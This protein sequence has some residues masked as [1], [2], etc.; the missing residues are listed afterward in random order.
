MPVV[1]YEAAAVI[2]VLIL[3]GKYLETRATG[4]TGAAIRRLI[5]LQPRTARVI[6]DGS[7]LEVAIRSVVVGD[8]VV[9]RPGE[10]IPVDATVLSGR[11][12]VDESMLTGE[13]APVEKSTG[14]A[15]FAA[16]MNT[17]GAMRVV[18]TRV[19]ADT[20]LQHVV[21]MVQEAQGSKAPIARLAD[22]ISGV[23]VP[24]VI[25][26]AALTFIVWW[27]VAPIESRVS[28][29]LTTAVSVLIIACPC[30]LGL[31]TPTAIMVGT[32]RGAE[33][34]ILIKGGAALEAA[35]RLTTVILDKTGTI[36]EGKPS[37]IDLVPAEGASES[38]LL[39]LAASAERSS[40]HP[41][42]SAIVR[43]ASDRGVELSEPSS[44]QAV[45]GQGVEAM[46]DGK[47]V[48]VG[49]EGLLQSQGIRTTLHDR[50]SEFSALGRTTMFVAVDGRE[51]GL[52]SVADPV[53]ST[54]K[55]AVEWLRAMGV[56]VVM[57]TGDNQHTAEAV[58]A[59]VGV[60]QVLAGVLPRDKS[61]M[62][63]ELQRAGHTVGM[64]GD[65]INDAPALARAD[66]GF[67]IG[68]GTDVAMDAA[69][70]TLMR[71]DLGAVPQAIRLSRAT[72]RTIRQNLF[73]AFIYNV[74][75]IPLAAGVLYPAMGW[76]LSPIVASAAMAFS[77]VSVVMNS[78][79][80]RR[81][82]V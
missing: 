57:M 12:A 56:R 30:A 28:M 14:A 25:G 35:H 45:V 31:A 21:R 11:S 17:T 72:M 71:G 13:S 61:S 10:K 79:R 76:L 4:R 46:V 73:W 78:L 60:D 68:T 47:R 29:A 34:G 77:S 5:G 20:A 51:A 66:V 59:S 75:G 40:E 53:R 39:R 27:F 16:T 50:A 33:M 65:G 80:L 82:R 58:A 70:I 42:A 49:K 74:V 26:I 22:R 67:A 32:G 3:L 24:V 2:V 64:V 15:V 69:D 9:V 63:A 7:E 36:T 38:D 8:V 43:G 23:F 54:S 52:L 48:L 1:Y 19:G 81:A 41:L 6:R 37:L 62:V 55:A 18:A 44:F